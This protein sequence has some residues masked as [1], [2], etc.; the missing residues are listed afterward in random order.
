MF[1]LTSKIEVASKKNGN[2]SWSGVN[3]LRI[4]RSIGSYVDTCVIKLPTTAI[5]NSNSTLTE[6]AVYAFNAGD[7]ITVNLGY[8]NELQKEFKGFVSKVGFSTPVEIE[9]EGYSYLLKKKNINKSWKTTTLREVCE[10]ITNGTAIK[11]SD[12][13]PEMKLTNY[14]VHNATATKV[15][16]YLIDQ[17][18]LVA[19]FNFDELYVGLEELAPAGNVGYALGYNTA[20]SS[21][22]KYQHEDE[23]R[24]KIVAKTTKKDGNK[25][26][27]SIG[28]ADGSVKEIIVKNSDSIDQIKKSAKDYLARYKYTGFTGNFTAFLQPF[29]SIGYSCK[30]IDQRYQE[31]SGT[32]FLYSIEVTFGMNGARRIC[33]LTKK[34]NVNG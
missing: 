19:Y 27:Y 32:Y 21:S 1:V 10:Y 17:Y 26:K 23:V 16:E 33:E 2:I 4:K 24:M 31:R 34:L 15:L 30:I 28:D 9:C 18:K 25:Q 14:K 6:Q 3:D 13:I 11:L 22:L 7:P 12:A 8:N 5:L 29:A 20:D